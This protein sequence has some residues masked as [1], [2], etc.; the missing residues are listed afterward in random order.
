MVNT[1]EIVV[2][3]ASAGGYDAYRYLL[4]HLPPGF[5]LPVAAVQHL[6]PDS[7]EYLVRSLNNICP[8]TIRE[9]EEKEP[10]R[11]GTVYFA[12]PNYHLLIESDRSFAL[13]IDPKVNFCRPSIDVLFESAADVYREALIGVLLTGANADGARGL[14]AVKDKGGMTIVQDPST[15]E[16]DAMPRAAIELFSVDHIATLEQILPL[17][18]QLAEDVKA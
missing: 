11:P 15:A 16:V 4:S 8:L 7:G 5:R 18:T 17:M 6:A 3:G 9:A 12:P 10:V 14:K 13:S 2:I 1:Y